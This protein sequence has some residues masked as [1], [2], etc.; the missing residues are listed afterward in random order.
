MSQTQAFC[1]AGTE[2]AFA[3]LASPSVYT[4]IGEATMIK[5]SGSKRETDDATNH[6]ST[7]GYREYISTIKDGGEYTVD[8][9]LVP[10]NNGQALVSAL[11]ESGDTVNWKVT[12]PNTKGHFT[13][14]AFIQEYG[15]V[16][17]PVD[18]KATSSLKIKVTGPVVENFGS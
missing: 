8:Y 14:S 5:R 9:N 15:N 17:F 18:K 10:G 3:S 13:F 16:D 11:F 4:T 12:M 7:S 6:D 1:P 2:I